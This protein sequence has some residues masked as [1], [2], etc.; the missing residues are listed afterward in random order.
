MAGRNNSQKA[1]TVPGQK[2]LQLPKKGGMNFNQSQ[3][4]LQNAPIQSALRR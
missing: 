4:V 1:L 2:A 3:L